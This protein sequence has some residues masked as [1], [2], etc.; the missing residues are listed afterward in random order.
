M[1]IKIEKKNED[2]FLVIFS[3]EEKD[4]KGFYLS[5]VELKKLKSNLDQMLEYDMEKVG[6]SI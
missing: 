4:I 5:K 6:D 3:D 1:K 2:K